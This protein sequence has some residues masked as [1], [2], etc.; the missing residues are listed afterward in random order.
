MMIRSLVLACLIGVIS[1]GHPGFAQPEQPLRP[2][3]YQPPAAADLM[4]SYQRA[5]AEAH[6]YS[7]D[8]RQR[9]VLPNLDV[10]T[11]MVIAVERPNRLLYVAEDQPPGMFAGRVAADGE[12][13]YLH[14]PQ[15]NLV[16]ERE[17]PA[18]LAELAGDP[19]IQ[20]LLANNLELGLD[21]V[22]PMLAE[23]PTSGPTPY[24]YVGHETW[25]G[26]LLHH[27]R[28]RRQI[29][30][31]LS[32]R[33]DYYLTDGDPAQLVRIQPDFGELM[34]VMMRNHGE[35]AAALEAASAQAEMYFDIG[36]WQLNPELEGELFAFAPPATAE[37][38][39][40]LFAQEK[41]P[42]VGSEAPD[43]D[44]PLLD[45]GQV[46]LSSHEGSRIVI[47]DFW[48]TWCGPCRVAMP[49]IDKV[50]EEF[51][52][53]GVQLY[54]VNL[55]ETPETI[56]GF[57]SGQEFA[58]TV[59]LDAEGTVSDRFGVQ[60]IPTTFIIGKEGRVQAAYVG[61][62]PNLEQRLRRD[63]KKLTGGESLLPAGADE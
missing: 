31:G 45:G 52:P 16:V 8:V 62:L 11:T 51:A 5:L 2:G 12:K 50:S 26:R 56:K 27:I 39:D 24:E 10:A 54:A 55:R 23:E 58:P 19:E 36:T 40:T 14:R 61:A 49:I 28:N 25:S 53:Q 13:L 41:H 3:E 63:L 59:L 47:L 7:L 32:L 46:Q 37:V 38:S 35:D 17:A 20:I 6:S 18:D 33:F 34:R 60:G 22:L 42:L 1:P 4:A 29:D 15:Q 57:L 43:F 48:A 44:L 21:L 9:V 30:E